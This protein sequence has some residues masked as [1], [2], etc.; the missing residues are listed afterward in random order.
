MALRLSLALP[1]ALLGACLSPYDQGGGD[2]G[3]GNAPGPDPGPSTMRRLNRTEY[4]NTVRDLLGDP[5]RPA[6]DFPP[7]NVATTFDNNAE[8]LTLPSVL[9]EDYANAAE[10]LI[11]TA[12]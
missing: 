2:G 5:T 4:N 11:T 7:D 1:F 6:N 9:L 8:V 10:A 3:A 12:L